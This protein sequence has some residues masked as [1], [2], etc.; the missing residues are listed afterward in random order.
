MD[1][2]DSELV[3]AFLDVM[4]IFRHSSILCCTRE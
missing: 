2:A 4:D 3:S 1:V